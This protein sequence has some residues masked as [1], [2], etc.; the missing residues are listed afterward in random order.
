MFKLLTIADT[1]SILNAIFGFIAIVSILMHEQRF[2]F[3]FI[4]LALLAD[5][6]DGVIARKQGSG[7]IGEYLE[8]MADM[9]SLSIAPLLFGLWFSLKILTLTNTLLMLTL[10]VGI[11]F[12]ICSAIRLASFHVLKNRYFF[13]GL[14]ASV[15]TIIIVGLGILDVQFYM[16][17]LALFLLSMAMIS[18]IPFPKPDISI[19][20]VASL[21]IIF[22]LVLYTSFNNAAVI[23][24]LI[25]I[26][27]YSI[28]GPLYLKKTRKK[29]DDI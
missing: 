14:P 21:L 2:A 8:A 3:S 6:L 23:L 4:L 24:L 20:T 28:A 1:I 13:V 26:I 17:L 22:S 19:N 25:A 7:K 10:S 15:S 29:T 16:F 11:L 18:S 12:L 27:I 5:G 9:L